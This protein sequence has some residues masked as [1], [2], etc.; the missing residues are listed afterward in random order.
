ML[1]DTDDILCALGMI[2][3]SY[4]KFNFPLRLLSSRLQVDEKILWN[5]TFSDDNTQVKVKQLILLEPVVGIE[6]TT[7]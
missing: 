6:P 4:E 7:S 3:F 5:S 2:T 1:K